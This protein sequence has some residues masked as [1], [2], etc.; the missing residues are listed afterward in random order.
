MTLTLSA[1][2]ATIAPHNRWISL[3]EPG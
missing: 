2:Y 1:D 3:G